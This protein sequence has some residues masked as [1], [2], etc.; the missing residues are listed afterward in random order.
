LKPAGDV[1]YAGFWR[2]TGAMLIDSLLLGAVVAIIFGP[3]YVH[4]AIWTL[5]G[6]FDSLLTL[7]ITVILWVK[8]VGTPGKLLM[9]CQV[10]DADTL[11]PITPK[12]A[13]FRY[14]GYYLSILSLMLGFLWIA[15]DKKKQGFH[16]KIANTV[17]IYSSSIVF[18]DESQ[19][20]LQQ[21]MS[22]VR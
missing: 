8:F 5:E 18:D 3:N 2:R 16:D 17:V 11:R 1:H 19:K 20:S 22:E 12:Q 14:L 7:V 13:I 10:V 15:W 6:I 4:S 21:L 9:G